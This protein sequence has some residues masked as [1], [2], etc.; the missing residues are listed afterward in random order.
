[1]SKLNSS[2]GF[3]F[4]TFKSGTAG[5]NFM[6]ILY[7]FMVL[8]VSSSLS[9]YRS[10]AIP[11]YSFFDFKNLYRVFSINRFLVE[12]T[13][14]G[15]CRHSNRNLDFASFLFHQWGLN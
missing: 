9:L 14:S 4:V 1:M 11:S 2:P 7:N 12:V 8:T 3:I 5:R 10:L 6:S 15:A 13:L